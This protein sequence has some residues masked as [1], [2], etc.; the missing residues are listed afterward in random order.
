MRLPD[1]DAIPYM[2]LAGVVL[3]ISVVWRHVWLAK[4]KAGKNA[5]ALPRYSRSKTDAIVELS[6]I[7][8][9]ATFVVLL[10]EIILRTFGLYDE[11]I[12]SP[13]HSLSLDYFLACIT[14]GGSIRLLGSIASKM[15]VGLGGDNGFPDG[16][17]EEACHSFRC[18]SVFLMVVSGVGA[19]IFL[20]DLLFQ[21]F[22]LV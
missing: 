12:R 1:L 22:G 15:I 20:L 16:L 5:N 14:F 18:W 3:M 2:F 17:F 10:A 21:R 19:F 6:S 8:F 11:G 9:M 13:N 7:A 4:M